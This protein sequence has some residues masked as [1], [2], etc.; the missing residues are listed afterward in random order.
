MA[1]VEVM[2]I[3]HPIPYQG[4]KR[5]LASDLLAYLPADTPRLVEPFA[6]SG[7][8]SLAAA[9]QKRASA[10]YLNDI[11]APLMSLWDAILTQPEK[12]AERYDWLWHKQLEDR[13]RY[14]DRVRDRFNHTHRPYY[15]LYLLARCV[16][17]SVRYNAQGEFNQSP[18]NRRKG[19]HPDKMHREI[20]GAAA[21]LQG[22]TT[23]SALDY[24]DVLQALQP[25]DVVYM[26]P[27]YQGVAAGRD[28]RY[29][30]SVIFEEFVAALEDLNRRRVAYL[31]SYDGRTGE[32]SFGQALPASLN[33]IHK[34]INAGRSSQATLLGRRATTYE[35][36]YLSPAL[37]ER[38]TP[39]KPLPVQQ[40]LNLIYG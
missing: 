28:P 16:K 19:K 4:S 40:E 10:F 21:L 1:Q 3:P 6:G 15:L 8:L 36:L 2:A 30:Q 38:L 14:Y 11:N 27:P 29:L 26:D 25:D 34:E 32:K 12:L 22:K 9:A 17:A 18:D 5:R 24:R 33:L 39:P 20:A 37:V 7:A 31:V 35:S 13:R 23:V